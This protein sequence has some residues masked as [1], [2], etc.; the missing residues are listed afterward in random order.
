MDKTEKAVAV[1]LAEIEKAEKKKAKLELEI[2]AKK[3]AL[4]KLREGGE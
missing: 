2:E 4:A 3:T 1:L